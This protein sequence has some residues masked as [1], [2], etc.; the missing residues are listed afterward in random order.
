MERKNK[1]LI[2]TAT[3]IVIA[4]ILAIVGYI[5]LPDV[6]IMQISFS[7]EPSST[8]PKLAGLALPFALSVIFAGL[9]YSS[10]NKKNLFVSAVGIVIFVFMFVVNL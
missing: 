10:E 6:L 1:K 2:I 4:V 7:G 8:L 3:I 9:Y 5:V